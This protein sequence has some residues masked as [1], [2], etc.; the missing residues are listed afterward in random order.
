MERE[1]LGA[2]LDPPFLQL[3][4]TVVSLTHE[5]FMT[6]HPTVT[7]MARLLLLTSRDSVI[8]LRVHNTVKS[9]SMV[10]KLSM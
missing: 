7:L 3:A 8:W 6:K 10:P 2:G 1:G 5:L 9:R 4:E